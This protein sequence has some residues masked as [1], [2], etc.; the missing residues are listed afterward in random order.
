MELWFALFI[1]ELFESDGN[2]LKIA[3]VSRKHQHV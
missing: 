3:L 1:C 2:S